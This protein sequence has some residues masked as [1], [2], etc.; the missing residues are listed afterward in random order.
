MSL[1]FT[2]YGAATPK[3]SMKA[4][5]P[6]GWKRAIL[7]DSNEKLKSWQQ[8]VAEGAN[9][10]RQ[11][12]PPSER[13]LMMG[14]VRLTLAFYLPRPKKYQRGGVNPAHVS[15]PDVDKLVRGVTDA[16]K[17]VAWVD[18]SQVVDLIAM[19]RYAAVEQPPYVEVWVEPSAGVVPLERDQPLFT[20]AVMEA[21]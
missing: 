4:F 5:I 12:Q 7:T 6:K 2:V 10:A 15:A 14:A 1:H 21:K 13:G 20:S 11:Q 16:L 17:R 18:D 8:L 3:G 9:H 19:K